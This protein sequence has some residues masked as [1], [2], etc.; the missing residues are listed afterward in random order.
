MNNSRKLSR[1]SIKL[2]KL[3]L[4]RTNI[5]LIPTSYNSVNHFPQ[6]FLTL[7]VGLILDSL[8]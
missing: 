5:Y 3:K 6:N 7:S 2:F 4:I 8:K 1:E